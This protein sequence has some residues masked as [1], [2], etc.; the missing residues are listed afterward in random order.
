[1]KPSLTGRYVITRSP[2]QTI[3]LARSMGMRLSGGEVIGLCGE[4]GGGKTCFV[5]GLARG[6]DV[7]DH[8]AVT[9]PTYTLVNEYP[10]RLLLVHADLYRLSGPHALEEIGF[11][12]LAGP[13]TVA[14]VEWA[15]RAQG[16]DFSPDLLVGF[17]ILG[18]TSRRISLYARG[19][20]MHDLVEDILFRKPERSAGASGKPE[21]PRA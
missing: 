2:D 17:T 13:G 9:S 11:F 19:Q 1:M 15:E 3:S 14:A 6:L 10:G 12:D 5:Q 16:P 20:S 4:L 18:D 8:V 21:R 7:P